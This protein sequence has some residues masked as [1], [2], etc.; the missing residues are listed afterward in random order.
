[1]KNKL[2]RYF[3]GISLRQRFLVAPLLALA[4]CSLLTL[5]FVYEFRRQNALLSRITERDLTAFKHYSELFVNLT[6][7]HTALYDLLYSAGKIDEATLYDQAKRH[8]YK[9]QQGVQNLEQALPSINES[10]A[11]DFAA[12]R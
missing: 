9:V 10:E 7:Q 11:P 4:V 1:M 2:L 8:L 3:R 6:E 12:L 5:A